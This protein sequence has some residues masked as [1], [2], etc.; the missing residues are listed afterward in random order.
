V[1]CGI[2]LNVPFACF[3]GRSFTR[4]PEENTK[5]YENYQPNNIINKIILVYI[6]PLRIIYYNSCQGPVQQSH[7]PLEAVLTLV[8]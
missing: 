7:C 4:A 1:L 2:K 8:H 3:R 6:I 5:Q